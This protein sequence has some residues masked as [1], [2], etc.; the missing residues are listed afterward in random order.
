M[1][2]A[3]L[4]EKLCKLLPILLNN[5]KKMNCDSKLLHQ[6]CLDTCKPNETELTKCFS[7]LQGF[8]KLSSCKP[9]CSR[10]L[11]RRLYDPKIF[12]PIQFHTPRRWDWY[13]FM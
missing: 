3:K 2:L 11:V 4:L 1:A 6:S 12:F 7:I 8:H 9:G 10:C 5:Y 13:S